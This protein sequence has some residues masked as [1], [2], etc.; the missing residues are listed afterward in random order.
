M[1][2]VSTVQQS[3]SDICIHIS[4]L[5]RISFPFRSKS[6]QQ[7]TLCLLIGFLQLSV[8]YKVYIYIYIYVNSDLPIHHTPPS[9]SVSLCVFSLSVS[10]CL[11]CIET[12]SFFSS[13]ICIIFL[14]STC[15]QYYTIL[16]FLFWT[17]FPQYIMSDF[18]GLRCIS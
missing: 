5:F 1:M 16:V 18:Q 13:F 12:V 2:S 10:L 8:L 7:S 15:K 3:E 9:P 4:P 17:Y 14:D 6:S 11:L